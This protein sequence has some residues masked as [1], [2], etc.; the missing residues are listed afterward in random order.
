[1]TSQL[2]NIFQI[3]WLLCIWARLWRLVIQQTSIKTRN[4]PIRRRYSPQFRKLTQELKEAAR[5][6]FLR[7]ICRVQVTHQV[8]VYL[9]L[10]AGKLKIYVRR[11]FQT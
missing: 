6:S 5:E 2:F 9:E 8:V 7:E 11:Q 1:M 3:V 4:I 10:D